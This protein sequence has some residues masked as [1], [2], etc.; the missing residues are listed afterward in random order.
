MKKRFIICL[1]ALLALAVTALSACGSGGQAQNATTAAAATTTAAAATTK[2]AETTTKAAATEAA[3]DDSLPFVKVDW[4]TGLGIQPDNQMV[5]DELN[6]YFKEKINAE[7]NFIFLAWDDWGN[8]VGPMIASG[9]DMGVLAYGTQA[10]QNFPNLAKQNAFAPLND[11][12]DKYAPEVK[13]LFVEDVW[14]CMMFNGKIYG[15]PSLKDNCYVMG[16]VYNLSMA[17]EFGIDLTKTRVTSW[18]DPQVV[19]LLR[20]VKAKRDEQHPEWSDR[21]VLG[22]GGMYPW[23]YVFAVE[24]FLGGNLDVNMGVVAN[25]PGIMDIEGYDENTLFNLYQTPQFLD[26]A[27]QRVRNV[28][29][30][31][32]VTDYSGKESW[33][34]DG[35]IFGWV[36]WGLVR[37]DP[38]A[39]SDIYDIDLL[40]PSR[41]WTSTSNYQGCGVTISANC[42]EKER[43]MMAINI[44]NTDSYVATMLRYGIEDQHYLMV[45]GKMTTEGS[46][47]NSDPASRGYL[48]WYGAPLGNLLIVKGPEYNV[49]PNNE[50][51]KK[52]NEYNKSAKIPTHMGFVFDQE[53]VMN[54]IAACDSIVIEYYSTIINGTLSSESDVEPFIKEFNDKLYANG[55]QKISD[56]VR[57]QIDAWKQ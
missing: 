13:A 48:Y 51:A 31:I 42:A 54:E 29:E 15:V 20:D 9:Q 19:N 32:A 1:C 7:I 35:S 6:K 17:K 10:Q 40:V 49:G 12:L 16:G 22:G 26:Y 2:A 21:P 23:P 30:G 44:V 50:L 34:Q 3:A 24:T 47:R 46:P 43:A 37:T 5:N 33:D 41:V 52:L 53:P 28:K 55:L 38:N 36:N 39:W 4:Y 57:K 14:K 8:R 18:D 11:L 27:I 25:I 56:E 45:D